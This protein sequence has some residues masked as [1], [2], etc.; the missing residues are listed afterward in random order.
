MNPKA[1]KEAPSRKGMTPKRRFALI[2]VFLLF[3]AANNIIAATLISGAISQDPAWIGAG[4]I[5]NMATIGAAGLSI[6]V[7]LADGAPE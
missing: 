2:L 4:A 6:G 3:A 5:L 1:V 7:A